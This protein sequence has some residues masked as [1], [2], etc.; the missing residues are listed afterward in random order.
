MQTCYWMC[1]ITITTCSMFN[2]FVLNITQWRAGY[3]QTHFIVWKLKFGDITIKLMSVTPKTLQT[4]A[5][6]LECEV[7]IDWLNEE[8]RNVMFLL[9]KVM[10]MSVHIPG[11]QASK[12]Y[13]WNEI[14]SYF[15]KFSLPHIYFTFIHS[16]IFQVMFGD[17]MVVLTKHY[18]CLVSFS[19]WAIHLAQD[20]VAAADFFEF[21]V[22]YLFEHLFEWDYKKII[23]TWRY[24]WPFMCILWNVW[25]YRL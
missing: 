9:N 15:S 16:P 1:L 20:P 10:T 4:F 22:T 17:K 19:E 12:I 13:M 25:I 11:S 14:R 8:E 3:L 23:C 21:C 7:K 18:P 2:F 6:H 5:D 24:F